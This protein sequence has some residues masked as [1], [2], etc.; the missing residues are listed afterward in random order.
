MSVWWKLTNV[1]HDFLSPCS[2]IWEVEFDICYHCKHVVKFGLVLFIQKDDHW[3]TMRIIQAAGGVDNSHEHNLS[4]SSIVLVA[5][6]DK[7]KSGNEKYE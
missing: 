7:M 4:F 3:G 6:D 5:D 2:L 1:L